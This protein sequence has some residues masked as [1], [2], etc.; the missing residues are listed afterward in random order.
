[1]NRFYEYKLH[2]NI[3]GDPMYLF[4]IFFVLYEFT[5]YS[6]NDMIMPGMI[7]VVNYFKVSEYYVAQ[8]FSLYILGNS[9]F[10]LI[11]GFLSQKY[12]KRRIILWGNFL[13]LIFSVLVILS[14]NIN[15]FL[16]WRFFQGGGMAIIAIS[17]ALIHEKFNDKD[18]IK[19]IALMANVSILAP[20]IGPALG[21]VIVSLSSWQFVFVVSAILS[22]CTFIGLYKFAPHDDLPLPPVT[23]STVFNQYTSLMKNKEFIVGSIG[24]IFIVLPLLIW[25]S[26]APNLI[27]YK[28]QL[29]FTDYVIY[30]L[31]S[32]GGLTI[33][34]ILMQFIVGKYRLYTIV[35]MG[36]LF[37]TIGLILILLNYMSINMIVLGL[38]F[39]VFGMGLANGCISRLIITLEGYPHNIISSMFGFIQTLFF[40]LGISAVNEWMNHLAFV[41]W[42]FSLSLCLFG[43]IGLLVVTSFISSYRDR[44]WQ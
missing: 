33:A 34:S 27:L 17:Y 37:M 28:L 20:L 7:Q 36:T 12:G 44:G 35:K 22:L 15:E 13:F 26:Q 19:L 25:I 21:S 4:A 30:Q 2:N 6:A 10:I 32:I 29:S 31:T 11:A 9:A 41:T 38:F 5:T 16:L 24:S 42:S 43:F 18:A 8:S 40:V 1:L 39:Y 14:L 23:F 3:Q